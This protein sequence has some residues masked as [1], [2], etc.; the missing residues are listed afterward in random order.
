MDWLTESCVIL[1]ITV[2]DTKFKPNQWDKIEH[3]ITKQMGKREEIIYNENGFI[4]GPIN[5]RTVKNW[6][7]MTFNLEL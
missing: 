7:L 6:E 1:E 2:R 4:I 3:K 5:L